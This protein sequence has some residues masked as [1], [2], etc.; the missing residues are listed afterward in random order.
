MALDDAPAVRRVLTRDDEPVERIAGAGDPQVGAADL[1]RLVAI[2]QARIEI[3]QDVLGVDRLQDVRPANAQVQRQ[4]GPH[5]PVVLREQFGHLEAQVRGD[6]DI[7]FRVRRC[8]TEQEI[9]KRIA[10]RGKGRVGGAREIER[11]VGSARRVFVLEFVRIQ[12][13]GLRRVPAHRPGHGVLDAMRSVGVVVR[14]EEVPAAVAAAAEADAGQQ[15][16]AWRALEDLGHR[17]VA[18]GVAGDLA[19][20]R[21]AAVVVRELVEGVRSEDR[22]PC[23]H[24]TPPRVVGFGV[25][26]PRKRRI[27]GTED[28][29]ERL[30]RRDGVEDDAAVHAVVAREVIVDA[31]QLFAEIANLGGRRREVAVAAE[32]RRIGVGVRKAV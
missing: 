3:R 12:Q 31:R 18:C 13:A 6:V 5:L 1:I 19:Q 28:L 25:R 14:T 30:F 10:G 29:A 2:E 24:S 4:V 7:V 32:R 22:V 8:S 9:R 11:A 20:N 23:T 26:H 16:V 21:A 27:G 17:R 15:P